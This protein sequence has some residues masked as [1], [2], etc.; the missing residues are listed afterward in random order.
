MRVL[1]LVAARAQES[2]E[3]G[4]ESSRTKPILMDSLDPKQRTKFTDRQTDRKT[5]RQKKQT[6]RRT[7]RHTDR[8]TNNKAG[9]KKT[10]GKKKTHT[11]KQ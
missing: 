2:G 6:D 8:Q 11:D 1:L 7:D 5:D 9:R 3:D 10:Y 4:E